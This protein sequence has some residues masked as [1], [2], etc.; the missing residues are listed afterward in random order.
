MPAEDAAAATEALPAEDNSGSQEEKSTEGEEEPH[1][2]SIDYAFTPAPPL[3]EESQKKV[4]D[5]FEKI[6]WLDMIE[7]HLLTS[8]VNEQLGIAWDQVDFSGGP[9]AA[10]GAA[11]GA[12]GG[13]EEEQAEEKHVPSN[14]SRP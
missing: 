14:P 8:V 9:V 2:T 4:D 6:L 13:V 10:G 11:A 5:L 1:P 7:V 12:A 3:S